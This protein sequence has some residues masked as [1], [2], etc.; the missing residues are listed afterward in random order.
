MNGIVVFTY[1]RS[2]I[3]CYRRYSVIL[4]RKAW[5]HK[6]SLLT[7]RPGLG[8][9]EIFGTREARLLRILERRR[10]FLPII[11]LEI[12]PIINYPSPGR[13][14]E[15]RFYGTI[16]WNLLECNIVTAMRVF[17][18]TTKTVL[19]CRPPKLKCFR[20]VAKLILSLIVCFRGWWVG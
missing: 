4:G 19:Q 15:S 10:Y 17:D 18:S 2:D 13:F 9:F 3:A 11:N 7:N 16:A 5:Y 20:D 1:N 8:L 12:G 14:V 6:T